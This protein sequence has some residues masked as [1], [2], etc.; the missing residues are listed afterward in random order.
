LVGSFFITMRSVNRMYLLKGSRQLGI[1]TD[2]I[3]GKN[4]KFKFALEETNFKNARM[5][6][7]PKIYFTNKKH[8]FYFNLDNIDG[9]IH[10]KVLFDNFICRS[11]L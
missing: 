5:Q 10:E 8:Y 1:V 9:E 2:G 7:T 3:F 4:M 11:R 6:R